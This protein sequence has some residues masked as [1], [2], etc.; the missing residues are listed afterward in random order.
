MSDEPGIRDSARLPRTDHRS[1][2]VI[3]RSASARI[4][5]TK[6]PLLTTVLLSVLSYV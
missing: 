5:Q 2:L 1:G 3:T 4:T 6:R